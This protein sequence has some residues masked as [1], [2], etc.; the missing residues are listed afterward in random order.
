MKLTGTKHDPV[1]IV[2]DSKHSQ[3]LL[4][5]LCREAGLECRTANNGKEALDLLEK[6]SYSL[7]IVDLMMPVMDG[8]SFIQR[9]M[10]IE[11]ESIVLVQTA[12]DS[13]RV[14]I[15]IMKLGVFDYI[16]KPVEVDQF[17]IALKKA[18]EYKKL[19][20][21]RNR[22]IKQLHSDLAT[23]RELQAKLLPDFKKLTGF[24]AAFSIL[25]VENLSGDFLDG[26]LIDNETYQVVL[27]DVSGHG[28]ASSYIGFEI[29]SIFRTLSLERQTP[30][31][32]MEKANLQLVNDT[33]VDYFF[34]TIIVAQINI[35]TGEI[36][37]SSGGHLPSLLYSSEKKNCI[38]VKPKGPLVGIVKDR[39]FEDIRLRMRSGDSLLLYTDGITESLS[40]DNKMYDSEKLEQVFTDFIDLPSI[41]IVHSIIDSVFRFTDYTE[42]ED[43]ITVLCLKKL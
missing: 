34:A 43:D 23:I 6:N 24:D 4:Q 31:Q 40:P 36:F 7:Y 2:E 35:R 5:S 11:P 3:V 22:Q 21:F 19:R 30:S 8:R 15:D 13:P 25:P 27:C 41:D 9:L 10:E 37:L 33:T 16:I 29:R 14:I 12:L 32:L 39:V 38:K 28:V 18:L 17:F 1:L 20:D 42:Q 26:Y